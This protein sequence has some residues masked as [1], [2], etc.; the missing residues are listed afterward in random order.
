MRTRSLLPLPA[1]LLLIFAAAIA[2]CAGD[3]SER[4]SEV[5]DY[6]NDGYVE[7]DDCNDTDPTIHPD[8]TELCD[9]ID[10]DCSGVIDDNEPFDADTW[11]ADTDGDGYGDINQPYRACEQPSGYAHDP[12]DCDDTE[13][14]VYPF[15]AELCDG[16]DNDCDGNV[17]ENSAIDA[18]TWYSDGDGDGYG[19]PFAWTYA[20]E[21]PEGY[22][23]D[24]SDCDD[25]DASV[26]PDGIEIC[27][28]NADEDCDGLFDDEDDSVVDQLPFY[29]DADGDGYGNPDS[30]VMACEETTG[31]LADD[32]DCDDSANT[33]NPG[34]AEACGDYVD[35]NCDGNIDEETAPYPVAWF[36]D[37]D[38]DGYGDPDFPGPLQ[39]SEPSGY[40]PNSTD[41]NDADSG[42]NPDAKESYYDGVDENCDG[43]SDYDADVDGYDRSGYG[44][45]DCDDTNALVNPGEVE[46]CGDGRDND[47]DNIADPCEVTAE[48]MGDNDDDAV[49]TSCASAGDWDKDGVGDIIV[50]GE[51]YDGDG[52]ARG[53]AWIALGPIDGESS[54]G[55]ARI[56]VTGEADQ[57][58]AAGAMALVGDMDNDN[59]PTIAIGA[60]GQDAGGTEAGAVYLIE[61]PGLS[62]LELADE[63]TLIG[64]IA[65]DYAGVSVAGAGDVNADGRMDLIIGANGQDA[66]GSASGAAYLLFG[67][68]SVDTDLSY[69]DTRMAGA[70]AGNKAGT[71]VGGGSDLNSDGYDDM[72]VGAPYATSNGK[73]TGAA[74]IVLGPV[75]DNSFSLADGDAKL[76]GEDAG[77]LAGY[78]VALVGDTDNDGYE[79]IVVGAPGSDKGSSQAGAFFIVSGQA[80]SGT[81]SLGSAQARVYGNSENDWLG[82]ATA[83]GGDLDDDG[84][85]DVLV[86]ARFADGTYSNIGAGYAIL[87]PISGS[88][89]VSD[90]DIAVVGTQANDYAGDSIA[91]AGDVTQDGIDDFLVGVP[92]SDDNADNGGAVFLVPGGGF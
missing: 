34:Q 81:I 41:C 62:D 79:D 11:Y 14:S 82:S 35:N 87:G 86:S 60:V 74:Y 38:G 30:I 89:T 77:D 24:A 66:G 36:L 85:G 63:I 40:A 72:I 51:T 84:Y 9:G 4:P 13:M 20:C 22:I 67:P 21:A 75:D 8:A 80:A 18:I 76:V 91:G 42:V 43:L 59:Y 1:S 6:D 2:G 45:T 52:T 48:L 26:N 78:A 90:C 57:D 29:E 58:L 44:G 61:G 83:N 92:G 53:G 3:D 73:Y 7:A 33:I 37:A 31:I 19:S 71:A 28:G 12:V 32:S 16:L 39:C 55:N 25:T 69:A 56:A 27:A 70:A 23:E 17:D 64:E 68:I 65:G 49:G 46:V 10:N 5:L 15:A 88:L 50:G 54:V 47:C